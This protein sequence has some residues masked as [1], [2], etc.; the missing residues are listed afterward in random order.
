MP[1]WEKMFVPQ[2]PLPE[3]VIRGS[4]MY[5]VLYALLRVVLK[6]E[7]GTTGV[8][9]LLVIVLLADAAQNGMAGDYTS[10]TD[11]A[12]LVAVIVGWSFLLDAI[13]Y[14]WPKAAR[15][16]RP[17]PL[18]LVRDGEILYRNLRR[19]FIT[20]DELHEQLREQGIPDLSDVHEARMEPDGQF[21]V[22]TRSAEEQRR[23]R[24]RRGL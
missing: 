7:S 12:L 15:V 9:N 4:I 2:T 10:V 16:I 5:L 6:R 17:K 13:A 24:R 20:V 3:V 14:R 1:D 22:T 18:L 23:R 8:T 11:G 19:E 21:S